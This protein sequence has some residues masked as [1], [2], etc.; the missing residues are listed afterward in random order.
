MKLRRLALPIVATLLGLLTINI[1]SKVYDRTINTQLAVDQMNNASQLYI[2]SQ[3]YRGMFFGGLY[4]LVGA[5]G[6]IWT[7]CRTRN[8]I[9]EI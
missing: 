2:D 5:T 8:L 4:V 3:S 6:I 1:G 7:A 9:K